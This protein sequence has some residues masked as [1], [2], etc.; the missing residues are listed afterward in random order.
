M[1]FD[2][3]E[4][5][6]LQPGDGVLIPVK[7]EGGGL[8]DGSLCEAVEGQVEA[9]PRVWDTGAVE[10]SIL[11]AALDADLTFEPGHVVA[12]VRAGCVDSTVCGCGS[13]EMFFTSVESAPACESC[14]RR[15]AMPADPQKGLRLGPSKIAVLVPRSRTLPTL[16][17]S[18]RGV[19]SRM[20]SCK[21]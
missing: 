11:V 10:G 9:I 17:R 5:L 7:R 8:Q 20:L 12:E 16:I 15:R 4:P 18:D 1:T 13:V 6:S 14:V 19:E 21:S 2:G 3:P